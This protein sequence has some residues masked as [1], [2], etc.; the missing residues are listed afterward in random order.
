MSLKTWLGR[1]T[2]SPTDYAS[3]FAPA[4]IDMALT[5]AATFVVFSGKLKGADPKEPPIFFRDHFE[6]ETSPFR[7]ISKDALELAE[8]PVEKMATEEHFPATVRACVAFLLLCSEHMANKHMKPDNAKA[9]VKGLHVAVAKTIA[10]QFGFDTEPRNTFMT[11]QEMIPNLVCP[12]MLN[13]NEYGTNDGL[14]AV[15]SYISQLHPE[16]TRLGY[17]VGATDQPLNCTANYLEAVMSVSTNI[18]RCA[19]DMRW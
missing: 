10:G 5:L 17:V 1:N 16:N 8:P 11:F 4:L 9:F 19:K 6:M 2:Q 14:G 15:L 18:E 3:A 7:A 12:K 13:T